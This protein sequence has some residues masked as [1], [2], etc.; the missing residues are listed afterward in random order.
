MIGCL[1]ETTACVV[2]KP[3]VI[4][5]QESCFIIISFRTEKCDLNI[6]VEKTFHFG[7]GIQLFQKSETDRFYSLSACDSSVFI[8][9]TW[10]VHF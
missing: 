5:N 10:G 2:A 7:S 1:T 4:F 9:S 8:I 3:L 6:V